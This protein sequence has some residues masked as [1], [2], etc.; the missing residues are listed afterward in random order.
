LAGF[1]ITAAP[2]LDN[3]SD[4]DP[5]LAAFGCAGS[6]RLAPATIKQ[7]H[8]SPHTRALAFAGLRVQGHVGEVSAI[9]RLWSADASA[10]VTVR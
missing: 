5:D 9:A 1:E 2:D 4:D 8:G 10:S 3:V 6:P 7:Q